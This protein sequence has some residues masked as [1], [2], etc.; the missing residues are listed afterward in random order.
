M[1]VDFIGSRKEFFKKN[2]KIELSPLVACLVNHPTQVSSD[3]WKQNDFIQEIL[4]SSVSYQLCYKSF[5][6]LVS[7]RGFVPLVKSLSKLQKYLTWTYWFLFSIGS[8]LFV[9]SVYLFFTISA[10][11]CDHPNLLVITWSI[12]CSN[13][14]L[15]I[16][17]SNWLSERYISINLGFH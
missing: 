10:T 7:L 3:L 8:F 9:Q 2:M 4:Y 17:S 14:L 12:A 15:S 16:P 1:N 11:V 13:V 5:D 6:F